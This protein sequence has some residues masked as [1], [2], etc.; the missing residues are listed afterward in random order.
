MA[1]RGCALA[2]VV[3]G[4][5]NWFLPPPQGLAPKAWQMF[6]IFVATAAGIMAAPLPMSVVAIIG[7]TVASLLD[8]SNLYGCLTQ[9]AIGSGPVI[10]GA[11]YVTQRECWKVGLIMSFIYLSVFLTVGP[12]WW[13]LL[14]HA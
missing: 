9:Y 6:A 12:L 14:G 8:I 11:G 7:A 2:P 5:I 3:I 4:M 1:H 10:F 13:R